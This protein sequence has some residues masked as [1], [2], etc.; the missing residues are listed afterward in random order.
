[1]QNN[2]TENSEFHIKTTRKMRD[3][4][5]LLLLRRSLCAFE[6]M[7]EPTSEERR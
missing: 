1:M 3:A 5:M 4:E 2:N 7:Q 6:K